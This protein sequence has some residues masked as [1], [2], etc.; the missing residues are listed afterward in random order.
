MV[1]VTVAVLVAGAALVLLLLPGG[2]TTESGPAPAFSVPALVEGEPPV[3]LAGFRGR[4]VVMNFW[5]SWC[6]PCKEEL[7]AFARVHERFGDEVAFV[8]INTRDS[9][10]L[11]LELEDRADVPYRSGF[12]PEGSVAQR[13]RLV[14]MPTTIFI[15]STGR[16]LERHAGPLAERELTDRLEEHFG[17]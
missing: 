6:E 16:L 5:A 4:P 14:G 17:V 13:Y 3:E 10:R 7:P 12:D 8:G 11:G 9:R 2:D 15:S 1:V